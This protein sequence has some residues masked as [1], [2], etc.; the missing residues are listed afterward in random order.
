MEGAQQRETHFAV[1]IQVGVE[2]DGPSRRSLK[3][4]KRWNGR[5][6]GRAEDVEREEAKRIR[7]VDWPGQHRTP[8][9]T[10]RL[11]LSH[12][13]QAMSTGSEG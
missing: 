9:V 8:D 7:C 4:D 2:L 6:L 5:I 13:H 12:V 1:C 11:V 3:M 10:T